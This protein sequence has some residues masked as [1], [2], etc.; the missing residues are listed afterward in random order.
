M[1]ATWNGATLAD[2]DDTIVVE[3]N[4]YFPAESIHA[5]YFADSDTHTRRAAVGSRLGRRPSSRR[6]RGWRPSAM[7]D[8]TNC[9]RSTVTK[10]SPTR[11][12]WES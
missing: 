12:S 7:K 4:H 9:S 3:D 1:K 8:V 5:E 6:R 2:S 10:S 11:G